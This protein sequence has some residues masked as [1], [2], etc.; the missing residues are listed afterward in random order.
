MKKIDKIAKDVEL[1]KKEILPK[2]PE[3]FGTR[4]LIHAFFGALVVGLTFMFKGLLI[5]SSLR[6][7]WT[8]LT[9]IIITTIAIITLEV[10]FIGYSRVSQRKKRKPGQFVIKRLV[11]VYLITITVSLFL[12]NIFGISNIAGNV[13]NIFKIVFVLSMPCGIGAALADLFKKY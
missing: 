7:T 1:L 2:E 4:D 3:H 12:T 10:Y 11:A 8:N 6:L 5:E 13:E 9:I